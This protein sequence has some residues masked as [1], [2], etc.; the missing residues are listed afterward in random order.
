MLNI[1]EKTWGTLQEGYYF[2][3]RTIIVTPECTEKVTLPKGDHCQSTVKELN[4]ILSGLSTEFKGMKVEYAKEK[5]G[6]KKP[7]YIEVNGT[8][9]SITNLRR[10]FGSI[11]TRKEKVT[12]IVEC[13]FPSSE[14][15]GNLTLE[16]DNHY[17]I[18]SPVLPR[19]LDD[20]I[21]LEGEEEDEIDE[22]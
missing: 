16:V 4:S 2:K 15:E 17:L 21:D 12:V 3:G 10:I 1:K 7:S 5:V 18:C 11:Y 22:D 8:W 19:S 6:D 14:L 20:E 13:F 9:Y